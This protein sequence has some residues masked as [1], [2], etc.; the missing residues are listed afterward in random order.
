M[1]ANSNLS[2]QGLSKPAGAGTAS[3]LAKLRPEL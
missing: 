1:Q 2:D 3:L